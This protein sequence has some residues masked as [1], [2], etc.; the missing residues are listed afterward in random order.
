M[1]YISHCKTI[2]VLYRIDG[3]LYLLNASQFSD[4]AITAEHV[5]ES[6]AGSI[7]QVS[8]RRLIAITSLQ[9]VFKIVQNLQMH[10]IF[11]N[12]FFQLVINVSNKLCYFL[13]K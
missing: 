8:I 5:G 1:R 7:R 6:N 11:S 10:C 3:A 9:N 13:F 2:D 4:F 12:C